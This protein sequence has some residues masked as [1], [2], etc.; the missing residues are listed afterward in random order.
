MR[1][2]YGDM[3]VFPQNCDLFKDLNQN[4]FTFQALVHV[5][6]IRF[7]VQTSRWLH[8]DAS[9]ICEFHLFASNK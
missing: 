3:K 7:N 8:S 2:V 1:D 6:S 4:L 5:C 9:N